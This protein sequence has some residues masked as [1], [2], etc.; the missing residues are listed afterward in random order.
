MS[1]DKMQDSDETQAL[2]AEADAARARIAGRVERLQTRLEPRRLVRETVGEASIMAR[3]EATRAMEDATDWVRDHGMLLGGLAAAGAAAVA[4]TLYSRRRDDR[5]DPVPIYDAYAMEDPAMTND[6]GQDS[7]RR[8][9]RVRE[10][11]EDLGARAS[12][13]YRD[14]RETVGERYREVRET[15]AEKTDQLS[16]AARE[17]AARAREQAARAAQWTRRQPD[18]NPMGTVVAGFAIGAL[19]GAL[20]PRTSAENRAIGPTKDKLTTTVREKAHDAVEAGKAALA[21]AGITPDAVKA[22]VDELTEQAK[23]VA[24]DVADAATS[25]L[26]SGGDSAQSSSQSQSMGGSGMGGIGSPATPSL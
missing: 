24:K 6:D 22:K 3:R 10:G 8:W 21:D 19:V 9:D 7:P 13:R 2:K 25:Q 14:A 17:Q 16:E 1:D 23:H 4:L 5:Y 26:K 11:A 18:E 15:V 12:E 20:L